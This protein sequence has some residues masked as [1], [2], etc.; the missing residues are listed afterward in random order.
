MVTI[1][2]PYLRSSKVMVFKMH[3]I[4][5]SCWSCLKIDSKTC[6][7]KIHVDLL[8]PISRVTREPRVSKSISTEAST[9]CICKPNSALIR[10]AVLELWEHIHTHRQ[11]WCK[12][13]NYLSFALV[14]NKL[15]LRIQC[16][17]HLICG[18]SQYAE[19]SS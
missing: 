16:W 12:T 4:V 6:N 11:T 1:W 7:T 2:P 10:Q 15:I 5:L 8:T 17:L 18:I 13:N 19:V 14:V 9:Q 3:Y